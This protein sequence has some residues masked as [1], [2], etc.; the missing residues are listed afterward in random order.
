MPGPD[1]WVTR[2]RP[3]AEATAD[4]LRERGHRPLVAPLLEIR[5]LE[6][7]LDPDGVGALAFTSANAIASADFTGFDVPVFTVGAA[8]AEAARRA[9]FSRVEAAS[10][11]VAALASLI[12]VRR[13]GF[14]GPVL[15]PSATEPAGDLAGLL[16]AAGVPARSVPVYETVPAALPTAA[17]AE[18][19]PNLFAVLLHSAKAA[20]RLAEIAAGWSASEARLL[21]LSD[22]VARALGDAG[23]RV[24]VAERP[25]EASLLNLLDVT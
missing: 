2:A 1:V 18:A 3:A 20:R 12:A 15:H 11:D 13:E 8:T 21:C 19:W 25:D 4:R 17:V 22:A 24:A 9:G 10:G 5:R 16:A 7:R 14:R 6:V 23:R